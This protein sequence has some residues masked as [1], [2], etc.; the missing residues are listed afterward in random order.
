MGGRNNVLKIEKPLAPVLLE[1]PNDLLKLLSRTINEVRSGDVAVRVA[2]CIGYLAGQMSKTFE[3]AE[4]EER[5]SKLEEAIVQPT[6]HEL[7][8]PT[9]N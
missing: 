8:P 7:P 1:K 6:Y 2:N 3:V 5:M 4:L 9:H